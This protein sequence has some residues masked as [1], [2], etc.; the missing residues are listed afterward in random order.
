MTPSGSTVLFGAIP[1]RLRLSAVEKRALGQFVDVLC[2]R[3]AGMRP[4]VCLLADDAHLRRLN[5]S[6]L[7][8]D[9]ATD[10]LAFP[11][12]IDSNQLGEIAISMERAAGQAAEFGHTCLDEV[13]LLMLHG[14]LH[15]IGLDHETG[16]GK[17]AREEKRW[18][19]EFSL[20][21]TLIVRAAGSSGGRVVKRKKGAA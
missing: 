1:V 9:Y 17:M 8:H 4:F 6:F 13:R 15:L 11:A 5:F 12:V 20:P 7:N 3:V 21:E 16:D 18:R 19:A 14:V 2:R 10:V